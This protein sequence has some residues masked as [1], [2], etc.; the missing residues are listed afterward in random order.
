VSAVQNRC[1]QTRLV[2]LT[3]REGDIH[4]LFAEQQKTPHGADLLV[5]AERTRQR[6]VADGDAEDPGGELLWTQMQAQPI[7]GT[8]ELLVPPRED[9][10]A[11]IA[12]LEVRAKAVCLRPPKAKPHLAEVP[13]WAILARE[14]HPPEGDD[15]LEWMLLTTVALN[16]PEDAFIRLQWYARRWGIEVFH[17]VLKSGCCIEARQLAHAQRLM[18]CMAIDMIVAWRIYYLTSQG[19]ETTD[20]PCSVYFSDSEWKALTTFVNRTKTPP[21]DPPSLNEAV[22]LLGKLGGHLGR[23]GDGHPGC[24]VLWRGM[25]RLADVE[26]AY[27]LYR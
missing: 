24:E 13:A 9:R 4:E 10:P 21:S 7:I 17:R 27:D 1:R 12:Q 5:R 16:Q 18:N 23:N 8:R 11:R 26:V 14:V 20:V 3:D 25:A 15:R 19:E 6:K 22:R 2:V